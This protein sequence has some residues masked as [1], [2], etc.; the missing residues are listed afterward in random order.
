VIE[1]P[2]TPTMSISDVVSRVAE[3][4]S[5]ARNA[6]APTV[7]QQQD[8]TQFASTLAASTSSPTAASPDPV[9]TDLHLAAGGAT[10]YADLM[11]TVPGTSSRGQVLAA[12]ETQVG[13][14]EQPPGSNDGPALA[15][16]R[17]AVAGAQPGQPW[18][19]Y[20]A[21][22]AAA[23]AGEPL[24]EEGQGYGS[25]AEI[26]AWAQRTGRYLPAGSTPQPGDLI[27]FGDRHV[28]IVE[29]VNADGSLSTV[30]GNYSSAVSR[31]QRSPSEATGFVRL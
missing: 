26:T 9:S 6:V 17:A 22:W 23:Q 27:L 8:P 20:F 21:S 5:L 15:A 29:S 13:Q 4:E 7:P 14:S 1:L 31:V 30:E 12:A 10:S 28:G 25:V 18:C 11:A 3:L 2:I 24:G 16:Y 19:A